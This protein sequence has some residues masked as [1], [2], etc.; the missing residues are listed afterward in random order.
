[1]FTEAGHVAGALS[2]VLRRVARGAGLKVVNPSTEA[3]VTT[4]PT[5]TADDVSVA[6]RN[7]GSAMEEWRKT[8]GSHRADSLLQMSQMMKDNR[9][10]LA[11]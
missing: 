2:N 5:S 11:T 3:V 6:A 10:M 9:E 4:F 8:S 1:M 7:A